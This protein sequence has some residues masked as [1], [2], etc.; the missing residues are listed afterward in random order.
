[1]LKNPCSTRFLSRRM[2]AKKLDPRLVDATSL[3]KMLPWICSK[4][5]TT[6]GNSILFGMRAV[7]NRLTTT[8]V[9]CILS[10]TA[11]E[12]SLPSLGEAPRTA[13]A[14][15][16]GARRLWLTSTHV[17]FCTQQNIETNG[18]AYQAL[19]PLNFTW[20]QR[21][22]PAIIARARRGAWAPWGRG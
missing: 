8:R 3:L 10:N 22:S 16:K 17:I 1:M 9:P 2:R 19:P 6:A 18:V 5:A 11:A 12:H 21:S 15:S 20:G 14:L 13:K 4:R 7:G